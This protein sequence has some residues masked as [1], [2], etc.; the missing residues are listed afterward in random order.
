MFYQH[1]FS[2][3][4]RLSHKVMNAREKKVQVDDCTKLTGHLLLLLPKLLSKVFM[5]LMN[6][7]RM[8]GHSV[9]ISVKR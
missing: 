5:S 8:F 6:V 9:I 4:T 2:Y 1:T 3:N 7:D